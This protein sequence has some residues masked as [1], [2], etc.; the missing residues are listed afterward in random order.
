MYCR[1]G[2]W[3]GPLTQSDIEW[4]KMAE[5]INKQETTMWYEDA[6]V[7]AQSKNYFLRELQNIAVKKQE[8]ATK[9]FG[10]ESPKPKNM[11][12]AGEWL[13]AGKFRLGHDRTEASLSDVEFYAIYQISDWLTWVDPTIV[14]DEDGYNQYMTRLS[15]ETKRIERLIVACRLDSEGYDYSRDDS[16]DYNV[17]IDA[18]EKLEAWD[19]TPPVKV[20]PLPIVDSG[21][22]VALAA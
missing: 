1:D 16:S 4:N 7:T 18:I 15:T 13:R 11:A 2:V 21:T 6:Y 14:R 8:E 9:R 22:E 19:W 20:I 5:R 17:I 10:I 12:E 3:F